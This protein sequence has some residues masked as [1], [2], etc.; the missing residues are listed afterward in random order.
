MCL[1]HL[2]SRMI[3]NQERRQGRRQGRRPGR[4]QGRR[5]AD[6][7]YVISVDNSNL[8]FNEVLGILKAKDIGF[9]IIDGRNYMLKIVLTGKRAEALRALELLKQQS[10]TAIEQ[11]P[12]L[13]FKLFAFLKSKYGLP[14]N[15]LQSFRGTM[16][17]IAESAKLLTPLQRRQY[18]LQLDNQV[19]PRN[20]FTPDV[21]DL[22]FVA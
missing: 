6:V 15:V 14:P 2:R 4:R 12:V 10:L 5:Q 16:V 13:K 20:L 11:N 21:L 9:T 18:F 7:R 1:K 17:I 22:V 3:G 19:F 8:C